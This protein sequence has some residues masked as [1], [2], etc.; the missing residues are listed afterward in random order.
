MES[1]DTTNAINV[2]IKKKG[3]NGFGNPINKNDHRIYSTDQLYNI[4]LYLDGR[5]KLHEENMEQYESYQECYSIL[6]EDYDL[7]IY[8]ICDTIK[9]DIQNELQ[10]NGKVSSKKKQQ[11]SMQIISNNVTQI[12]KSQKFP[13]VKS[14]ILLALCDNE[15]FHHNNLGDINLRNDILDRVDATITFPHQDKTQVSCDY[16]NSSRI[17][18]E[19]FLS[20]SIIEQLNSDP[21]YVDNS[22]VN[23]KITPQ[24]DIEN[25]TILDIAKMK[26]LTMCGRYNLKENGEERIIYP[27]NDENDTVENSVFLQ[28]LLLPNQD[29]VMEKFD[30]FFTPKSLGINMGYSKQLVNQARAK[31]NEQEKPIAFTFDNV[32]IAKMHKNFSDIQKIQD[33]DDEGTQYTFDED[34]T[35][36][37]CVTQDF[38]YLPSYKMLSEVLNNILEFANKIKEKKTKIDYLL[39]VFSNKKSKTLFW[40]NLFAYMSDKNLS[41]FELKYIKF[42]FNTVHNGL[43]NEDIKKIRNKTKLNILS[44][45][46][47]DSSKKKDNIARI[48]KFFTPISQSGETAF[49]RLQYIKNDPFLILLFQSIMWELWLCQPK[50]QIGKFVKKANIMIQILAKIFEGVE[51]LDFNNGD[52]FLKYQTANAALSYLG[53]TVFGELQPI[54]DLGMMIEKRT[55]AQATVI[56]MNYKTLIHS[57]SRY[58]VITIGK[59]MEDVLKVRCLQGDCECCEGCE[60]NE[61]TRADCEKPCTYQC[62]KMPIWT[63]LVISSIGTPHDAENQRK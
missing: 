38:S 59:N 56:D 48:E 58:Q 33:G 4:I 24:Q 36:I 50:H 13:I 54:I 21:K 2:N 22:Y 26:L 11:S 7:N 18:L 46:N 52:E 17:K 3:E 32:P 61:H 62:E 53:Y 37:V 40:D 57:A 34:D 43:K 12:L 10:Q 45:L 44:Y 51:C 41:D 14:F 9:N 8:T 60:K 63:K 15:I 6:A 47:K 25:E 31:Y 39:E 19:R 5:I 29:P 49:E 30:I 16:D 35:K 23:F 1:N 20:G 27:I 42:F 28:T 55:N